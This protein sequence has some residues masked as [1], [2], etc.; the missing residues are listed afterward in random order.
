M[1]IITEIR[2]INYM[3]QKYKGAN[4]QLA[5]YSE[6]LSKLAIRLYSMNQK[7]VIYIIG[8]GCE[9][10][11]GPFRLSNIDLSINDVVNS[12]LGANLIRVF[13]KTSGFELFAS[14]GVTLAQGEESE[15]G[16]SFDHFIAPDD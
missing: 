1:E 16:T 10:I 5:F 14:G 7:K 6:S 15:F 13:D 2:D 8:I 3:L 12:E 4:L 9:K 11:C